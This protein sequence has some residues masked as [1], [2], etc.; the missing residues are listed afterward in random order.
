VSQI[1]YLCPIKDWYEGD[2]KSERKV[3]YKERD[4]LR[5]VVFGDTSRDKMCKGAA[6]LRH[7]WSN[8]MRKVPLF[9]TLCKK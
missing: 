4:G 3:V 5:R 6:K 2:L 7:W 9:G 8:F 1:T